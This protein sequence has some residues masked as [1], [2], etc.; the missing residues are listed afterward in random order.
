M[1]FEF[2]ALYVSPDQIMGV[3]SGLATIAGLALTFWNKIVTFF[4]KLANKLHP[5]S[6]PPEAAKKDPGQD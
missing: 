6:A 1:R 3:T 5:S 2:L 4:G